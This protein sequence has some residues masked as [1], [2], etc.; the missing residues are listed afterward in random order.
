MVQQIEAND[1][2]IQ[3]VPRTESNLRK[4]NVQCYNCNAKGHYARDCPQPKVR[5]AKYFR[6][7]MLLAMKDE[8]GG[9]LNKEENDFML[10]N[11]YGDDTL[12]ELNAAVIMM[13]RI[14]PA[15]NKD[16]DKPKHDAETINEVNVSQIKPI[17]GM[18]FESVHEHTN[19]V[20][21]KTVINISNDDQIDSSII[22]NDLYVDNNALLQKELETCKERVKTL[23][24]KPVQSSNYKEAYEELERE[25]R[26]DKDK[27]DNLIKEKDKIQDEFFQ[28]ENATIRIRHETEL[29]KKAFKA[30]ENKYL[31]DIVDLEEKLSSHDR[32]VYKM[33]QSI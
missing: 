16:D 10:D 9:N 32:I 33:G 15:E 1:Q 6:E 13:A 21:L 17:S 23:E 5:A 22:F 20:K 28:L 26:V 3:R 24:K 8:V 29:S 11:A 31:E 27:I 4:P 14:Q 7:Q 2:I 30:R 12:E 18:R 19:H 25:I